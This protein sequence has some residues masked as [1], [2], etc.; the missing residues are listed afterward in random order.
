ML[1]GQV[2]SRKSS[3]NRNGEEQMRTRCQAQEEV[4]EGIWEG[5][6]RRLCRPGGGRSWSHGRPPL[7][8]TRAAIPEDLGQGMGQ[9]MLSGLWRELWSISLP[10]HPWPG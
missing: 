2:E 7:L 9:G 6:R 10:P 1:R 4:S 8:V 5:C 3:D